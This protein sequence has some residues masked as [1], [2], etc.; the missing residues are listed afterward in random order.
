MRNFFKRTAE[1]LAAASLTAG[2]QW[3][4]A[5]ET[6][7][8]AD[9]TGVSTPCSRT[10]NMGNTVSCATP[11]SATL[12][13]WGTTGGAGTSFVAAYL[14]NQGGNGLGLQS[15]VGAALTPESNTSPLH[16]I[17]SFDNTELVSLRFGK[18]VSLTSVTLGWASTDADFSLLAWTGAAAPNLA[19]AI[20]GQTAGS[21]ISA[22]WKL[23]GSYSVAG[24]ANPDV[25]VTVSVANTTYSSYWLIG[26]F[27]SSFGGPAVDSTPD[28]WKLLSLTGKAT[29]AVPEPTSFALVC[30]ALAGAAG[31]RRQN[32]RGA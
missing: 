18:A 32:R 7:N 28:A 24:N 2:S 10:E 6:W 22:G 23:V 16:A 4:G 15:Q 21:L 25:D 31:V 5:A 14:S 11:V 30:L 26:A 8:F 20:V 17:D 19:T 9:T 29:A 1:L 13:G 3:A 12:N 27:N